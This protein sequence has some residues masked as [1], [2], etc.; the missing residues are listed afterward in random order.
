[1]ATEKTETLFGGNVGSSSRLGVDHRLWHV[2]LHRTATLVNVRN[3]G[4]CRQRH[5]QR[6]D[7]VLEP[8]A[9]N[10][11]GQAADAQNLARPHVKTAGAVEYL[12]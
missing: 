5:G 1:M 11:C 12:Q 8:Y 6:H 4:R 7:G 9:V 2:R 10:H 3:V